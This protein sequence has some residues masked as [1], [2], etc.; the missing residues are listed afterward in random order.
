MKKIFTLISMALFAVSVNAQTEEYVAIDSDQNFSAEF[1]AVIDKED[2][3]TATNIKDNQS[4]VTFGTTHVQASAV[5]NNTPKDIETED[6]T[7]SYTNSTWPAEWWNKATWTV[8]NKNKTIWHKN[9]AG[10]QVI[11]F[12][13]YAIKGDGNPV[14]GWS[15][16]PVIT[17]GVYAGKI[18]PVYD[19]FYFVPGTSTSVPASGEYFTFKADVAGM[20]RIGFAMPNGAN[21]YMYIVEKSTVRTLATTEFKVEGYV[22]GKDNKDGTPAWQA[23][24]KVNDDYSIGNAEGTT[25]K[26]DEEKAFN[27]LT[28]PK[29]GWFVFNAKA[30]E[31][32]YIFSPTT[33]FGFRSMEF[34]PGAS[35]DNYTP[36]EPTAI[37]SIKND[38]NNI[39]N[40][41]L[42]N[43][44]GQ[45]VSDDYKGLI[46]QNGKKS[47]KK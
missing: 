38:S 43:L 37:Q 47:I 19:G 29:F 30:D 25:W 17:E 46:I 22:N 4:V 16:E 10:E 20:F 42:Y 32:Y 36:S 41:P 12:K 9:E 45:K 8:F 14:T 33:Q 21:R 35:I 11:D 26:D 18:R 13:F 5:S 39:T 40:T 7:A 34:T 31:T 27:E 24:I 44:A 28:Q 23:S 1:A 6:Q 15:S 2:K 3:K